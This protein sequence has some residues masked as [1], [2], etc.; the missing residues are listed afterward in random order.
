MLYW[1]SLE[2]YIEQRST[3]KLGLRNDFSEVN[4]TNDSGGVESDNESDDNVDANEDK[5][6][7]NNLDEA[8]LQHD[9]DMVGVENGETWSLV[10][11]RNQLMDYLYC[12]IE[13][14]SL[15]Y[16]DFVSR[17]DKISKNSDQILEN[18]KYAGYPESAEEIYHQNSH[19]I[20]VNPQ[21][22]LKSKGQKPNKQGLLNSPH[23][24]S[25][26]HILKHREKCSW[27]I[28]VPTGPKIY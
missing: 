3:Q 7:T 22:N 11:T 17:I 4:E 23:P 6:T 25:S 10:S 26:T 18:L 16:W 19:L 9:I 1:P 27:L 28:P 15:C 2:I 5:H 24:Q 21:S 13:L 12:S 20:D 8:G 14:E